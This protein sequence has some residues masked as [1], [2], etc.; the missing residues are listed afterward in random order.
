M[1]EIIGIVATLFVLLSFLFTSEKRIRQIN[2]IGAAIFVVYGVIIGALS[3]YVLNGALIII[4]VYKLYKGQNKEGNEGG[5]SPTRR[6]RKRA[7][8]A[9]AAGH[10][11]EPHLKGG[12]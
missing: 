11:A 10:G 1:H 12:K 4:H 2:I 6:K 9:E 8:P 7:L 3:V 5:H